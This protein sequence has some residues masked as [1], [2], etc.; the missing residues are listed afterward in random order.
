MKNRKMKS[1]ISNEDE[2]EG[3]ITSIP[4]MPKTP[5]SFAKALIKKANLDRESDAQ[6]VNETKSI[7]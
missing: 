2:T 1:K 4:I 6:I 7:L 3:K 5:K